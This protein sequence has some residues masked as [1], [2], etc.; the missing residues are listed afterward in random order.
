MNIESGNQ[1][2]VSSVLKSLYA[3]TKVLSQIWAPS[4]RGDTG[5]PSSSSVCKQLREFTSFVQKDG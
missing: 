3:V 1:F 4:R 5:G 2:L